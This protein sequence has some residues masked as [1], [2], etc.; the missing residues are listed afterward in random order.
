MQKTTWLIF[1]ML[2]AASA[3][4]GTSFVPA[5]PALAPMPADPDA[6]R[7]IVLGTPPADAAR[8]MEAQATGWVTG[9]VS[10]TSAPVRTGFDL[11]AVETAAGVRGSLTITFATDPPLTRR[12]VID[13]R[14]RVTHWEV[15]AKQPNLDRQ[16]TL[17]GG[18][19][20]PIYFFV[21]LVDGV[22]P[23]EPDYFAYLEPD[24]GVSAEGVLGAPD[25][26]GSVHVRAPYAVPDGR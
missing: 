12:L 19:S 5:F 23:G 9:R 16:I 17:Y 7:Y 8:A 15:E 6:L 18:D 2:A 24:T 1:S 13:N 11:S 20:G 22:D 21:N 26:A 10:A 14:D 4:C 25:G 3:A